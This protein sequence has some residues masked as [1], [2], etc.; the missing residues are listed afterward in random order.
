MYAA[1]S[2]NLH[3]IFM[4]HQV[5]CRWSNTRSSPPELAQACEPIAGDQHIEK[6]EFPQPI[7][8][9]R[10]GLQEGHYEHSGENEECS[11][12]DSVERVVHH[13]QYAQVGVS[14]R[15]TTVAPLALF[16]DKKSLV[17]HLG[18]PSRPWHPKALGGPKGLQVGP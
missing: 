8:C 3:A 12:L 10:V 9:H 6:Q 13:L 17:S 5:Q 18:K 14:Q 1:I 15:A 4:G 2:C 11:C 16:L 7:P